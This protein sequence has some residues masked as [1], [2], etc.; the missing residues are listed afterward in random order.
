MTPESFI[1]REATAAD[2]PALARLHVATFVETHGGPG[3]TYEVREWQWRDA[4]AKE[5]RNWFCFVI[6]RRNGELIGFAK[7]MPYTGD[8]PGF[9]GELNKVY[10][11]RA[12]HR[13]GLGRLIICCVTRRFLA[14]GIMS[15]LLFGDASNPSNGFYEAMGAEPLFAANGAF[16]GGYGWRDLSILAK[17]CPAE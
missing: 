10:L 16:H 12:Y 11:L 17:R 14:Q 8:L 7:G 1:I 4:F 3:P 6:A 2:V 5:D 9:Y 15:M 13:L